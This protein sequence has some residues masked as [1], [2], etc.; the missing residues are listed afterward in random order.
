MKFKNFKVATDG[1]MIYIA[2]LVSADEEKTQKTFVQKQLTSL[3]REMITFKLEHSSI[4]YEIFSVIKSD[5]D[6]QFIKELKNIP[7]N[8]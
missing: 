6:E 4:R 1:K 7:P 8:Y 3:Q 2:Q 5:F